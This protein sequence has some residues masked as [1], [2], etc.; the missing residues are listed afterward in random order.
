MIPGKIFTSFAKFQGIVS[1]TDFRLSK[2]RETFVKSFPSHA[3]SLFYT[4]GIESLEWQDLVPRE[5]TG[6]CRLINI[7][8]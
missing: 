7:P 2:V 3:K 5:R 1:V 6:D 8:R 4:D